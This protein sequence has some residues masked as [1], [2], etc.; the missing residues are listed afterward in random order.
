L[1][2]ETE[3]INEREASPPAVAAQGVLHRYPKSP[4]P[5]LDG[6]SLR[7][8]AGE[9]FALLGPNGGGKTTLFRILATLLRPSGPADR[10]QIFG[11]SVRRDP[12]HVRR[13]LGV[14]FQSPSLDGKL[15][16]RENLAVHA[17][18][19]GLTRRS[20][21]PLIDQALAR[22]DLADRMHE[23]VETFSGGMQRRLEIAKA[24]LHGPRLLL[25]DE[26]A[27]GLDPAARRQLWDHLLE[28]QRESGV[29]IFW[30]THLLDEAERADRLAVLAAGK[31]RTVARPGELKASEGRH[32]VTAQPADVAALPE[33]RDRVER[34]LGPWDADR[35]PVIVDQQ[36][37]FDHPD[38]P[39]VVARVADL[40]PGQLQSLSVSQPTLEDAYLRLI[41][42]VSAEPDEG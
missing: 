18:L 21:R 19:Y 29:T 38:G 1:A 28:L 17:R 20:A 41:A 9:A 12:A 7:V 13:E 40:L 4:R 33:L 32:I 23:R 39:A 5:A 2:D 30:T 34:E 8:E 35:L 10:L 37:R 42:E 15:T 25:M 22:F 26:P 16:A 3:A 31:I 14:V 6:V 24:L 27:T 11:H 36:V